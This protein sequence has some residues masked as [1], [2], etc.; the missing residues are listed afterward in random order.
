M[1]VGRPK[2]PNKLDKY[3]RMQLVDH[4]IV[5]FPYCFKYLPRIGIVRFGVVL[6]FFLF[7]CFGLKDFFS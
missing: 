4:T 2:I 1:C 7:V 3:Q 6:G 5:S